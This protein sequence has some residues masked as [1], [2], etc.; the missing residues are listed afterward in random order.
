VN[1]AYR[2]QRI[3]RNHEQY[4]KA[5]RVAASEEVL[6]LLEEP[7]IRR[8]AGETSRSEKIPAEKFQ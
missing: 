4:V 2:P 7:K 1:Y 8:D 5:G 3:E 6:K